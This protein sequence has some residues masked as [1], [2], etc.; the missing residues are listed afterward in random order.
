MASGPKR[1]KRGTV[2]HPILNAV[3]CEITVSGAWPRNTF[4]NQKINKC[5]RRN[6]ENRKKRR[7]GD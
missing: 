1:E 4:L 5:R 2:M 6:R 7:R 3:M